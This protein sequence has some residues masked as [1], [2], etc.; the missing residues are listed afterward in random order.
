MP[1]PMLSVLMTVYNGE[2]YL[3]EAINSILVQSYQEFQFLILDDASTDRSREIVRSFRDSRIELVSLPENIGQTAALN[4]GLRMIEAAW[5]AR[6]DQDDISFPQRL[7]KQMSYIQNNP[8]TALLGTWAELI[9][10]NGTSL[11][12]VEKP[13]RHGDIVRNLVKDNPFMHPTVVFQRKAALV[14]GGYPS[15]YSYSQDRILWIKFC[16]HYRV[17][18][19]PH[20]LTKIRCHA[21]QA[22]QNPQMSLIRYHEKL[23]LLRFAQKQFNHSGEIQ[24][25]CRTK[26]AKVLLLY[27][28]AL[29][30]AG[31]RMEAISKL[32]EYIIHCP[33]AWLTNTSR[34]RRMI[35]IVFGKMARHTTNIL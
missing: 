20:V 26:I 4:Q 22:T 12:V 32:A 24:K 35:R 1:E 27:A 25:E 6:I 33:N 10:A 23:Q 15:E 18:N 9:S 11:G 5:V 2:A 14:L 8:D 29:S 21:A 7:E 16:R 19:I 34:W 30:T 3:K 31:R 17:A 28:E 13:E